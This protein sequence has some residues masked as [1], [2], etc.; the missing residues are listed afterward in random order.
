MC[1][2]DISCTPTCTCTHV[3]HSHTNI[4]FIETGNRTNRWNLITY[5]L[6]LAVHVRSPAAYEALKSFGVLQLPCKRSLQYFLGANASTPGVNEKAMSE[7]R[8]LY[9]AFCAQQKREG[10]K[11]PL[12][13][14]ILIFDEVKVQSKVGVI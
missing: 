10:K 7:Q 2:V 9:D 3:H 14:G 12:Y 11:V 5:R 4:P 1:E 8:N 13:E 6:A